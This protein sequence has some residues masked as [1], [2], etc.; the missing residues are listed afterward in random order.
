[1]AV[2]K[3]IRSTTPAQPKPQQASTKSKSPPAKHQM[4]AELF[5]I[6]H[7][8]NRGYGVAVAALEK[9]ETKARP[10]GRRIFP[11]GFLRSYR[12]RTEVLRAETNRDLLR[13]IAAYEGKDA[14]RFG[15]S[16]TTGDAKS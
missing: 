16:L 14:S 15:P 2:H 1:M 6:L 4:R 11:T 12:D 3:A 5:E 7:H 13:M 9:L 10:R 8:L